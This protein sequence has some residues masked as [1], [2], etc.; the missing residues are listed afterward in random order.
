MYYMYMS[1]VHVK[2][3]KKKQYV[4]NL[5]NLTYLNETYEVVMIS[6]VV[7]SLGSSLSLRAPVYSSNL[8]KSVAT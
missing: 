1:F 5:I 4:V 8:N 3:I 2:N 6:P 7:Q